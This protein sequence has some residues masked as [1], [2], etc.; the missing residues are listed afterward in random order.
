M[1]LGMDVKMKMVDFYLREKKTHSHYQIAGGC[2]FCL[3]FLFFLPCKDRRLP[4]SGASGFVPNPRLANQVM[5]G[6]YFIFI[7]LEQI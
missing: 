4:K 1:F 2:C 5:S 6:E 7:N 3:V